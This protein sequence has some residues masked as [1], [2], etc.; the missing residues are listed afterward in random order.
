MKHLIIPITN[1]T[2]I[3]IGD[4][5]LDKYGIQRPVLLK[6]KDKYLLGHKNT[7]RTGKWKSHKK[8]IILG[9]KLIYGKSSI[10]NK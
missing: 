4:I 3:D 2:I 5:I 10:K 1:N 6:T 7:F 8:L 9:D